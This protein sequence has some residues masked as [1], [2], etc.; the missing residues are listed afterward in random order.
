MI[1][2]HDE[3]VRMYSDRG[4]PNRRLFIGGSDA[5]I[6]MSPDEATLIRLWREK[7]SEVEPEDLSNNLVVQLG[8]ATRHSAGL[9]GALFRSIPSSLSLARANALRFRG[10]NRC[11]RP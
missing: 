2:T 9:G 10:E 7:R 11:R 6:I 3:L 1:I 4:R 5:Q 8:V